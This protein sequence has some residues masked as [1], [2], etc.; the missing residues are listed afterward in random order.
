M[1]SGR[2]G[3]RRGGRQ[4]RQ[5]AVTPETLGDATSTAT[6]YGGLVIDEA[7]SRPSYVTSF[8]GDGETI[9]N[10]PP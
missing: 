4:R 10:L 8:E 7:A 2:D 5:S 9:S 6:G 3:S 1:G